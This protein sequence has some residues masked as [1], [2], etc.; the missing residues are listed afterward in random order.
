MHYLYEAYRRFNRAERGALWA[1]VAALVIALVAFSDNGGATGYYTGLSAWGTLGAAIAAAVGVVIGVRTLGGQYL[2]LSA[3]VLLQLQSNF[4]EL[5]DKRAKAALFLLNEPGAPNRRNGLAF[6]EDILGFFQT[7][8]NLVN[9]GALDKSIAWNQ[10]Y[11]YMISY[12][13]FAQKQPEIQRQMDVFPEAWRDLRN[14]LPEFQEIDI[15]VQLRSGID[16]PRARPE[17]ELAGYLRS[18]LSRTAE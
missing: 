13:H 18:E 17:E 11:L 16:I 12:W 4:N 7:V 1:A 6:T 15:S 3:D 5:L 2:A 14:I 9:R 8:S 10:Y